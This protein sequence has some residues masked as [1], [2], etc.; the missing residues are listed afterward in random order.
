MPIHPFIIHFVIAFYTISFILDITGKLFA[1]K[2]FESVGYMMLI[3]SG[4]SVILAVASGLWEESRIIIPQEALSTFE[5]HENLAFIIS[6]IIL[7][8]VLWRI[9]IKNRFLTKTWW[10]YLISVAVGMICLYLTAFNGGK[11]VYQ[12]GT[13]LRLEQSSP[14]RPTEEPVHP[15][16]VPT[17]DM[18]YPEK[19]SSDRYE[20]Y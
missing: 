11:L 13:G 20:E 14:Q 16:K 5:T 6:A 8:Q 2:D 3:L 10:L 15:G 7:V 9:G 12:Y 4:I 18:F 19:D 17:D 1:K